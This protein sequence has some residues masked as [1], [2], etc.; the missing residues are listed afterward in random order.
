MWYPIRRKTIDVILENKDEVMSIVRHERIS[1]VTTAAMG[2]VGGGMIGIG[3]LFAAP[4]AGVSLAMSAAGGVVSTLSAGSSLISYLASKIKANSRLKKAQQFVKF[5][6]QFSNHVNAAAAKYGEALETFKEGTFSGAKVVAVAV[7]AVSAA[8]GLVEEGGEI[9]LRAAGGVL[10]AVT[11]PLDI[12]QFAYN[13]YQLRKSSNDETG[14]SDSD[15]TIQCLIKQFEVSL[16]GQYV[17]LS[18]ALIKILGFFH[19]TKTTPHAYGKINNFPNYGYEVI[20][21]PTAPQNK[22]DVTV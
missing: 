17:V 10:V 21:P 19:V 9:A 14:Q 22:P 5:D 20:L 18:V 15:T 1:K 6:Q 11:V 7:G 2:L 13:Y 8:R 4:T 16:K 3:F 12:A